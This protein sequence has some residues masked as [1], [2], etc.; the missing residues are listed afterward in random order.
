MY[1]QTN[2]YCVSAA[3]VGMLPRSIV[4]DVSCFIYMYDRSADIVV[5]C[6]KTAVYNCPI[7]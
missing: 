1:A 3:F 5:E 7:I 2:R 6:F 4:I